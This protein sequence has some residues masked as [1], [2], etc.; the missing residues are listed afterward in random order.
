MDLMDIWSNNDLTWLLIE[1]ISAF[2]VILSSFYCSSKHSFQRRTG[3][4]IVLITG[5]FTIP[6][7]IHKELYILLL[8]E[9]WYIGIAIRGYINNK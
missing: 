4:T 3:F 2:G 5:L 8:M 9:L 7:M 6:L 1:A